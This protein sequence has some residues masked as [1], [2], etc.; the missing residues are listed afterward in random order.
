MLSLAQA[1]CLGW[2]HSTPSPN[3]GAAS[4]AL[5]SPAPKLVS[6][7]CPKAAPLSQPTPAFPYLF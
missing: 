4:Q 7:Q 2:L 1:L 3:P 5:P 6:L